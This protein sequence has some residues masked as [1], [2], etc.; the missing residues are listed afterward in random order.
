MKENMRS[1]N[2]IFL[3]VFLIAGCTKDKSVVYR[4]EEVKN[5]NELD[6]IEAANYSREKG[7]SSVLVMQNGTVIFENYHNGADS[8]TATHLHSATKF[9]WS[10]IAALSIQ[11]GLMSDFDEPVSNTITEWQDAEIHPYKNLIRIKHLLSLSSG[12]SQDVDQIQGTDAS[13]EDIFQYVVDSLHMNTLPGNNFFYG[14][15]HYYVFGELLERKLHN[16]GRM[17][18]PLEYLEN[19]IFNKIG[20]EYESWLYDP[21]GNPHIPNGCYITPRNWL[22]FGQ[23]MLQKGNWNGNQLIDS[24]LVK[25]LF[26][27]N[28]P[29]TGHGKFCWLN[30]IDGEGA[31]P[32]QTAPAGS[33]GGFIYHN[34][35]TD[36]IGG[37]GAGKNRMYIIPSL[38]AVIVRQTLLDGDSYED[39]EFLD[40]I[41]PK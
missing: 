15:S 24:N 5:F 28:G 33:S 19:E 39:T 40:L 23:F 10:A 7:G 27:A 1:M 14:P 12:L 29:N 30:N 13:A 21:S 37:L 32:S 35:Y 20:L 8:N 26:I 2:L 38:N 3:L 16:D 17:L 22:K 41:L 11:Q 36:I 6:L 18:S 9:F 25:D 31:N 4:N 34:G